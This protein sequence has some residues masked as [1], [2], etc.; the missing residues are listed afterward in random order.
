M[1]AAYIFHGDGR[2]WREIDHQSVW[3]EPSETGDEWVPSSLGRRPRGWR[4][5]L[6]RRWFKGVQYVYCT[7]K[8]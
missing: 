8:P 7:P 5:N 3:M 2:L 1:I 4:M 6:P